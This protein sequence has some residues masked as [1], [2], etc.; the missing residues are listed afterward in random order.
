MRL[1]TAHALPRGRGGVRGHGPCARDPAARPGASDPTP[2]RTPRA[3][4]DR[5]GFIAPARGL[6][7]RAGRTTR[8]VAPGEVERRLDRR[9]DPQ[10]RRPLDL[11]GRR[12][13]EVLDP[14]ATR[15]EMPA[16][17]RVQRVHDRLPRGQR[18]FDRSV[19]DRM[20]A[21]LQTR[22]VRVMEEPAQH[23]VV[24]GELAPPMAAFVRVRKRGGP[25]ADRAVGCEV[26]PD[27]RE[28][29]A[30]GRGHVHRAEHHVDVDRQ[31]R[32]MP[33][34]DLDVA[35]PV[36]ARQRHLVHRGDP[37]LRGEPSRDELELLDPMRR[38]SSR[39]STPRPPGSPPSARSRSVPRSHRARRR[40]GAR[41]RSRPARRC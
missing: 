4:S 31:P 7:R 30:N 23:L 20:D 17:A 8:P 25:R 6:A 24:E 33:E 35:H 1:E 21:R 32:A 26:S 41:H 14:V 22:L 10:H 16:L 15:A 19:P 40:R 5:N 37:A 28:A 36:L 39:P 18:L 11:T 38:I 12:H 2:T 27:R 9:R 3:T 34:E 13:L 29:E